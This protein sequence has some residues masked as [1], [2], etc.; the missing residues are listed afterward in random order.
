MKGAGTSAYQIKPDIAIAVDVTFSSDIPGS[1]K[2][3]YGDVALGK[4]PTLTI[5]AALHPKIREYLEKAAKANDIPYQLEIAPGRTGTDADAIHG[6][7]P[8]LRQP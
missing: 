1:D 3:V 5:G 2:R 8:E 4:G 6:L 7:D